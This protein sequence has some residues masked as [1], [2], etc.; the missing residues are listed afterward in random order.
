MEEK[1]PEFTFL[2]RTNDKVGSRRLAN[3]W[4]F[5]GNQNYVFTSLF[6]LSG[7]NHMSRSIGFCVLNLDRKTIEPSIE[8]LVVWPGEPD[9]A[10]VDFY[11]RM[12]T[13][14][15]GL[16]APTGSVLQEIRCGLDG[17]TGLGLFS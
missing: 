13:E 10:K 11:K 12:V 15:Q 2:T 3:G 14:I 6:K 5:H 4:W 9:A 1:N 17:G 7:H 8:T 16:R